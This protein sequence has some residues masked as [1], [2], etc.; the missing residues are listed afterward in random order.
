MR[1]TVPTQQGPG[2]RQAD[3]H[4]FVEGELL[5][6]ALGQWRHSGIW[7]FVN[8]SGEFVIG[9]PEGDCGLTKR[10]IIVDT[11]GG[12]ARYGGGSFSGKD[13]TQLPP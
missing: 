8:S 12:Y 13:G 11:Y 5:P 1:G 4:A 6:K 2:I 3:I 7:L 10:K 9:G